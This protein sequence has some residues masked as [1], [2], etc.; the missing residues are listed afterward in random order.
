M[1]F[2]CSLCNKETCYF[3]TFCEKCELVSNVI[4]AEAKAAEYRQKLKT[5]EKNLRDAV[6]AADKYHK[7]LP[8][9]K[10][11]PPTNEVWKKVPKT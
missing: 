3:A 5:A 1:V 4:V 6:E 7:E 9:N 2:T 8:K 11:D 10:D